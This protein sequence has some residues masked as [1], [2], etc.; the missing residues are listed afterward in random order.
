MLFLLGCGQRASHL[1]VLLADKKSTSLCP[2]FLSK[3]LCK[4][5]IEIS[6][7]LGSDKRLFAIYRKRLKQTW[8]LWSPELLLV[9]YPSRKILELRGAG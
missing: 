2:A 5:W 8:T 3:C 1:G 9:Y 6:I 4:Y 7:C